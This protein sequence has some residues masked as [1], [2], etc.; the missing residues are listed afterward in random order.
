LRPGRIRVRQLGRQSCPP[1]RPLLHS[2]LRR[3]CLRLCRGAFVGSGFFCARCYGY[4]LRDRAGAF[5]AI[6]RKILFC[7]ARS[8]GKP[9]IA[10]A[11]SQLLRAILFPP[12]DV[13]SCPPPD[14]NTLAAR[15]IGGSVRSRK[16]GTG[17]SRPRQAEDLSPGQP[18]AC[19][20]GRSR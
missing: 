9:L 12:L 8:S 5:R 10:P 2:G 6:S 4:P 11:V 15:Y 14:R 7:R 18:G 3:R 17:K 20:F 1:S 16:P 13:T 19:G